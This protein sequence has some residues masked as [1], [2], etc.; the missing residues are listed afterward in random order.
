MCN[1]SISLFVDPTLQ[2]KIKNLLQNYE[3]KLKTGFIFK[4][5]KLC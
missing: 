3:N 4:S 1:I 2:I 5:I